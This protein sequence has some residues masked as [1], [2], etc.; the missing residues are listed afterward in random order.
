MLLCTGDTRPAVRVSSAHDISSPRSLA[1][2][3]ALVPGSDVPDQRGSHV[4][5]KR[6]EL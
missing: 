4:L 6:F 5:H 1:D 3:L 2:A